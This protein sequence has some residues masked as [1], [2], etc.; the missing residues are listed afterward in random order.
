[1]DDLMA[2]FHCRV[3]T[4]HGVK[5]DS[6]GIPIEKQDRSR[7]HVEESKCKAITLLRLVKRTQSLIGENSFSSNGN[8]VFEFIYIMYFHSCYI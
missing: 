8:R 7:V 6:N 4:K 1:M 5:L 3:L 2:L